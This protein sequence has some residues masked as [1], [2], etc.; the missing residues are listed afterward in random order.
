MEDLLREPLPPTE[1][2]VY[3]SN[4]LVIGQVRCPPDAAHFRDCG[5]VQ[6]YCVVF[7]RSAVLIRR[8]NRR[9]FIEDPT[10]VGLYN[11]GDVFERFQVSPEGERGEWFAFAPAIIREAVRP[12][13]PIAADSTR[14]ISIPWGKISSRN[15]LRQREI[16]EYVRRAE[17]PDPIFIE[18]QCLRLLAAVLAEVYGAA[19][20]SSAGSRSYELAEAARCVIDRRFAD[21]LSLTALANELQT[22]P[23]YLCR[24]FRRASGTSIHRYLTIVRLR[25]AVELVARPRVDLGGLAIQLGFNSH[26]HFSATFRRE[27]G[28]TPSQWRQN[29]AS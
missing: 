20:A 8:P 29:F 15:F 10:V 7:P 6:T 25:R 26:S 24:A 16:F 18:E 22:S 11:R 23:F 28:I 12:F 17:R 19:E 3:G 2:V 21:S 27:F 5:T 14:P 9:R 13:D 1:R 4:V